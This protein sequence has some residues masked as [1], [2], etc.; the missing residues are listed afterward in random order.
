MKSFVRTFTQIILIIVFIV[1]GVA[2][3]LKVNHSTNENKP[4]LATIVPTPENEPPLIQFAIV[5]EIEVN[6]LDIIT[7]P[8]D[9]QEINRLTSQSFVD[10]T[11]H[12]SPDGEKIVYVSSQND[13]ANIYMMNADGSGKTQLTEGTGK[14]TSPSWSPNGES[15]IF[16][17]DINGKITL[18]IIDVNTR[19]ILPI[20][21]QN[22]EI[23]FIATQSPDWS[24]DGKQV[25]F[26]GYVKDQKSSDL[27]L[28]NIDGSNLTLLS[29]SPFDDV[30]PSWS[31]DGHNIAF[32][33]NQES[34]TSSTYKVYI[35]NIST[36]ETQRL[37]FTNNREVER[38]P[39]WIGNNQ[40]AYVRST[41]PGD[42]QIIIANIDGNVTQ[43]VNL[44]GI[45][46]IGF[47]SIFYRG[48]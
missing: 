39:V 32:S 27:Y 16:T 4:P 47:P 3:S 21:F 26:E 29:S 10:I 38:S 2:S 36:N 6:N 23:D 22:T 24:P 25:V 13:D 31:P 46:I 8:L 12:W 43:Q 41:A 17:S 11:P 1:I 14:N 37:T 48:Q 33:S 5:A 42:N 44:Q 15:I 45:Q 35:L 34:L 9:S 7:F 30:S 28:V 40:L 19:H 18:K 20:V